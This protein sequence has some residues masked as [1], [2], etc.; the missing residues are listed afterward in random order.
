M[1]RARVVA[2]LVACGA[3]ALMSLGCADTQEEKEGKDRVSWE[4]FREDAIQERRIKYSF[5]ETPS[6]CF[7]TDYYGET[8]TI[9]DEAIAETS[10]TNPCFNVKYNG[11]IVTICEPDGYKPEPRT[12]EELD[13][14][15]KSMRDAG[16]YIEEVN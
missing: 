4:E 13:A 3:A 16:V 12:R 10:T 15:G 5:A 9:C 8:V 14:I 1:K 7:D 2:T 6:R 11:K